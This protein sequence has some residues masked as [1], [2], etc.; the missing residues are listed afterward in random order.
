MIEIERKK[1]DLMQSIG[2]EQG[3]RDTTYHFLMSLRDPINKLPENRQMFLRM[4]I[5]EII[6]QEIEE[7]KRLH[8]C[9]DSRQMREFGELHQTDGN[10][11][12]SV[13]SFFHNFSE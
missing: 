5:Q 3:D 7:H 11:H 13:Q 4:K 6:F 10:Q 2:K 12:L 1:L 9:T 8:S